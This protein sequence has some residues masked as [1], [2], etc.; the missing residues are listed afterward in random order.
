MTVHVV[1]C[2]P[3]LIVSIEPKFYNQLFLRLSILYCMLQNGLILKIDIVDIHL[4][5]FIHN[6]NFLFIL[7]I[8]EWTTIEKVWK[9]LINCS[10]GNCIVYL[11]YTSNQGNTFTTN[12]RFYNKTVCNL[13]EN[14]KNHLKYIRGM[15][16]ECNK[17]ISFKKVI[18]A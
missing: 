15:F 2:F 11:F 17:G 14:L 7:H 9:V 18:C 13:W 5:R 8:S 4:F 1:F 6:A 16:S 3:F 12:Q 10:T